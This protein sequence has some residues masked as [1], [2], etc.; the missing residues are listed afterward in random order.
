MKGEEAKKN[1]E[2]FMNEKEKP[3][4]VVYFVD[5]I[6]CISENEEFLAQKRKAKRKW[7][8]LRP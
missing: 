5:A 4:K 1:K 6:G 7:F 8:I 2:H 3:D